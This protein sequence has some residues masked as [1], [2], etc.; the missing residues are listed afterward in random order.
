[1][2]RLDIGVIALIAVVALA[3]NWSNFSQRERYWNEQLAGPLKG[4]TSAKLE[5]FG[6][7]NGHETHC[8]GGVTA[9]GVPLPSECYF[10]DSKSKGALLNYRGQLFVMMKMTDGR[11]DSHTFTR[12]TVLF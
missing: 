12:T 9:E 4:A 2:R 7:A 1:M 3:A 10:V 8:F 6:A 5:A 11:V